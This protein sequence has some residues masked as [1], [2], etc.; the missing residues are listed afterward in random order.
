MK[1]E[2]LRV[3]NKECLAYK[4]KF[5]RQHNHSVFIFSYFAKHQNAIRSPKPQF[6]IYIIVPT[7]CVGMR[8]ETLQR[9]YFNL[10]FINSRTLTM[11]T[12]ERQRLHSNAERWNDEKKLFTNRPL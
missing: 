3:I 7:L 2:N 6:W 8:L 5:V 10:C 11:K 1:L 12:L 9:P 4:P